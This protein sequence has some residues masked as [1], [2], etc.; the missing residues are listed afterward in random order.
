MGPVF[1]PRRQRGATGPQGFACSRKA[2]FQR[3]NAGVVPGLPVAY[4]PHAGIAQLVERNLAKVEVASSSL[5]SRSKIPTGPERGVLSYRGVA[6]PI[7]AHRP[8]GRVVMQR[9]A[10]P[11]TPVQFRPRPPRNILV[12][13]AS[14][15]RKR[16]FCCG[17]SL[18]MTPQFP[19]CTT[20]F[21]RGYTT[22]M[23]L[24]EPRTPVQFRPWRFSHAEQN[25][26]VGGGCHAFS[27]GRLVPS[28]YEG[29]S[30]AACD[31]FLNV[32]ESGR[33]LIFKSAHGSW[34]QLL[35]FG[36]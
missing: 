35:P 36:T 12:Y 27:R 21:L 22:R 8:G 15:P 25:P 1:L 2:C 26:V 4:R 3:E 19:L 11:R 7:A 13:Q 17:Q 16:A 28:L 18:F 5:V 9:P 20:R 32:P 14:G 23:R 33:R 6:S 29:M 31:S 24:R 34:V 30:C 10:K